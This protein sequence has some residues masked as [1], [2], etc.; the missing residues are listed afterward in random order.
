VKRS[1]YIQDT[2][3]EIGPM[4]ANAYKNLGI[5]V[6]FINPT[7]AYQ[8]L[9]PHTEFNCFE[10]AIDSY[11]SEDST[12]RKY[13]TSFVRSAADI[14]APKPNTETSNNPFFGNNGRSAGITF[15]NDLIINNPDKATPSQLNRIVLDAD[16]AQSIINQ[17]AKPLKPGQ[18]NAI[19]R[20]TQRR[21]K[22]L[23]AIID[24]NYKYWGD[25]L[26]HVSHALDP[27]DESGHLANYG[28]HAIAK[29]SDLRETPS[30]LINMTP[31]SQINDYAIFIALNSQ[32][33]FLAAKMKPAGLPI[34]LILDEFT[35][36]KIPNFEKEQ[37]SL[38]GL[39][40][41]AEVYVQD[42]GLAAETYGKAAEQAIYNQSD[43]KQFAA[44][45]NLTD[46]QQVNNILGT[47]IERVLE[48]KVEGANENEFK[49]LTK[50]I[51]VP[52]ASPQS[53]MAMARS[54]QIIK[55]R[56]MYPIKAKLLPFW[57]VKGLREW[58]DKNP[59]ETGNVPDAQTVAEV[60]IAEN[61][62]RVVWPQVPAKLLA[63]KKPPDKVPVLRLHSFM[64]AYVW[65]LLFFVPSLTENWVLPALRYEY[66]FTQH[67]SS[68]RQ[69]TACDYV[70]LNGHT[71]SH[72][73]GDCPLIT[74]D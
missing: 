7:G 56:G 14:F 68:S 34:H 12:Q 73:G 49:Y 57:R 55:I 61:G 46:A 29:F 9:C 6:R 23:K 13:M 36:A 69:Y 50:D 22:S 48:G 42:K 72:Y 41:S 59:L 65:A 15:L 43:I 70:A 8:D 45:D 32:A 47:R 30:V 33:I 10:A 37:I 1:L 28:E 44:I 19:A 74:W 39:K 51:E 54:S 40:V 18:R 71:F 20:D 5:P 52:I 24:E 38:R 60:K 2:K 11:W 66:T 25:F 67:G 26:S 3:C 31:L 62:M 64:W 58:F 17:W 63:D 35:V 53:L 4:V 16:K 21:A 27:F